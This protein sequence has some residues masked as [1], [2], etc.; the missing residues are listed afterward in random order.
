VLFYPVLARSASTDHSVLAALA[1]CFCLN[2]YYSSS[3]SRADVGLLL[4]NKQQGEHPE[5]ATTST[6]LST[7]STRRRS[8]MSCT[9]QW[10]SRDIGTM[11]FIS[12]VVDVI[13]EKGVC[14][15][16]VAMLLVM[17]GGGGTP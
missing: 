1:V 12:E 10:N 7:T 11:S 6:M 14:S 9:F 5:V 15:V 16:M 13:K 4:E 17:Q 8:T 3:L 2:S